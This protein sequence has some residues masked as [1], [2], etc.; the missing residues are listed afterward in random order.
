MVFRTAPG[1]GFTVPPM[2]INRRQFLKFSSAG[3]AAGVGGAAYGHMESGRLVTTFKEITGLGLKR[4]IRVLHLSDFHASDSVPWSLIRES[5][6]IG[7]S[8]APDLVFLTGDFVTGRSFDFTAYPEHV[9]ALKSHPLCFAVMGNHDGKYH[10]GH[11][12]SAA[13][14]IERKLNEVGVRT[15]FNRAVEVT[16]KDTDLRIAGL[17]DLWHDEVRPAECLKRAGEK[18]RPTLLLAHNPDTKMDVGGYAWDVMFSGH[19]HG[20]QLVIPILN[21]RP[22]LPV[23]D[24]SMVEGIYP[25]EGRHIHITRGVG[26]L[27]GMRIN[28]PPEIS[29]VDLE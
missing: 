16:V 23:D 3:I 15:L 7:L 25:W 4:K 13:M 29:L 19:T 2:K 5:V 10:R 12:L 20:G 21:W 8:H 17:G 18:D 6:E 14:L 28:C 22:F 26:C 1:Y 9:A 27:H 24:K 11:S